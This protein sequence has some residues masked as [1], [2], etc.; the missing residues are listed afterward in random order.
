[1]GFS[2]LRKENRIWRQFEHFKQFK[3]G[4]KF[5]SSQLDSYNKFNIL[6]TY[7]MQAGIPDQEESVSK[8]DKKTILKE[9][10]IKKK[11][12]VESEEKLVEVRKIDEEELLGE[13]TVKIGLERIYMQEKITVEALLDSRITGLAM[14][15]EFA[16]KMRFKLKKV[17][18]PIYV[19]NVDGIFNKEGLI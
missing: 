8:K 6:A 17:E 18:R 5:S 3:R 7:A 10:K 12:W 14:S 13:V 9:E 2:K 4:G 1:M 11:K 16:K 15:S 19:R